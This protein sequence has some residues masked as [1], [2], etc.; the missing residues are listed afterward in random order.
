MNMPMHIDSS[1][2]PA[3]QKAVTV[4]A[5]IG[6]VALVGAGL[7]LAVYSTRFVPSVVSRVGSAAVYLGSV[8][9]S[10]D[11][12][13]SVVSTPASTTIPFGGTTVETPVATTSATSPATKPVAT[14]PAAPTAGV[15]KN[16]SYQIGGAATQ[17]AAPSGLPDLAVSIIATGYLTSAS[18]DTFAASS[19]VPY[20]QRP[21]VHFVIKNAGT[22]WSGTWS[23][24]A[25]IP[26]SP[27]YTFHSPTQQSLAPGESI[28]YTL[29]FDS[30]TIGANQPISITIETG[31]DVNT[32]NNSVTATVT[33]LGS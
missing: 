17:A 30:A 25:S 19:S 27:A 20:G 3:R 15:S 29:G 6:F 5:V 13:L 24:S 12:T 16:D 2:S 23:F 18:A 22:N 1:A 7:S 32:N 26:T 4:L 11:P 28:E 21:A 14:T 33:V 31:A 9:H 8:F 10:D